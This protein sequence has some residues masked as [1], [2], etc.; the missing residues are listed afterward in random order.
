MLIETTLTGRDEQAILQ[1]LI[2]F[3][4]YDFSEF[5]GTDVQADGVYGY[6]YLD[7]YWSKAHYYPLLV[8]VD[9]QLAGFVLVNDYVYHPTSTRSIAEFFVMRKYRR[10]GVGRTVACIVFDQLPGRWEVRQLQENSIAQAFWRNVIAAYTH[11]QYTEQQF[12][13][14]GWDGSAQTFDN[15]TTEKRLLTS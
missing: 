11:G 6:D 3:Y 8:R 7:Y 12:T 9:H 15:T 10:R 4:Q 14:Y 2:E 1:R 5:E 13:A